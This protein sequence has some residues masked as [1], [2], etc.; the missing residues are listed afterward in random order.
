MEITQDGLEFTSED[1]QLWRAFL[2]TQ[3]GTRLIPKMLEATPLLLDGGGANEILIRS[4]MVKG[5]QAA[6]QNL[7]SLAY[8]TPEVKQPASEYP[9]LT[10]DTAWKDGQKIEIPK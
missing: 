9:A 5:F 8:P 1:A 4:G 6:A 3:T 10:D 7:L 2:K